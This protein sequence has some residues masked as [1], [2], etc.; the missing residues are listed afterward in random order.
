LEYF[1][2]DNKETA[3]IL[4]MG[5]VVQVNVVGDASPGLGQGI[6]VGSS[7]P[8]AEKLLGSKFRKQGEYHDYYEKGK[9]FVKY[10]KHGKIDLLVVQ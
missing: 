2:Y 7:K 1:E 6:T 5:T 10:N 9:A 3:F 8:A 4:D